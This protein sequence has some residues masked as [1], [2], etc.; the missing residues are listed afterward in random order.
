MFGSATGVDFG[1]VF[2]WALG[3]RPVE[4]EG[5]LFGVVVLCLWVCVS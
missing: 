1:A 4:D 2:V 3:F 5:N